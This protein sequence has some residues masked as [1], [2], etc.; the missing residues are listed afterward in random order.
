MELVMTNR[1]CLTKVASLVAFTFGGC[2]TTGDKTQ[3]L[4]IP[5]VSESHRK[6]TGGTTLAQKALTPP[7]VAPDA[8]INWQ[9]F[10]RSA[11]TVEEQ[12]KIA[13]R[14]D[15]AEHADT[16]GELIT[17][18]RNEVALGRLAK[19]EASFREAIRISKEDLN[20]QLELAMLYLRKHDHDRAFEL[21]QDLREQIGS[22]ENPNP[23]F[24]FRY[25][26][27]L[28]MGYIMRG[29][30]DQGHKILSDLIS[31]DKAFTPA[32][33]ALASSYLAMGKDRIAEF[34]A[35][36]GIDRG[37][38]D[39]ALLNIVG[40]T[41]EMSG[42]LESSEEWFNRSIALSPTFSP[43]LVNLA[44]VQI[45]RLE[46]DDAETTLKKA[47]MYQPN[48]VEGLVSLSIVHRHQGKFEE[49]RAAL[50][51]ALDYEPDNAVARL[52]LAVLLA[53]DMSKPDEAIRLLNEVIQTAKDDAKL[54]ET[55][56]N[57][58]NNVKDNIELY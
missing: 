3:G 4:D 2:R 34:I 8:V 42:R 16:Y 33:A 6:E 35:K 9:Q 7:K 19:A 44:G 28:A 54:K 22:Q 14:I 56:I 41:Q 52:N 30:R 46:F 29:D 40:V 55:A 15:S 36:R 17:R 58:L 26:Y 57:Y 18:G 49:A 51:K 50:T 23:T 5:A 48:N 10:F 53:D 31:Q 13:G 45:K 24:I 11:P 1:Q 38:E 37:K 21:L 39:P 27:T 32:Y 20:P 12:Q 43:A 25:R 47:L